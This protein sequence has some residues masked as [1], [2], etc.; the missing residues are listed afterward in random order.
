MNKIIKA[1]KD[2]SL[3]IQELRQ[4]TLKLANKLNS[5]LKKRDDEISKIKSS[6]TNKNLL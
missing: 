6:L 5:E 2:E 3:S 1:L 4:L